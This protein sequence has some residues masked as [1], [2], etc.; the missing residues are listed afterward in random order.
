ME[1]KLMANVRIAEEEEPIFKRKEYWVDIDTMA[2]S[3]EALILMDAYMAKQHNWENFTEYGPVSWG[4]TETLRDRK[5][6]VK[7]GED[8]DQESPVNDEVI[9]GNDMTRRKDGEKASSNCKKAI[10]QYKKKH[11]ARKDSLEDLPTNKDKPTNSLEGYFEKYSAFLEMDAAAFEQH[12][13]API[14]AGMAYDQVRDAFHNDKTIGTLNKHQEMPV[15]LLTALNASTNSVLFKSPNDYL[16]VIQAHTRHTKDQL[17]KVVARSFGFGLLHEKPI[18]VCE[19]GARYLRMGIVEY[20]SWYS[21]DIK[22]YARQPRLLQLCLSKGQ[23]RLVICTLEHTP[24]P[25][26]KN[27]SHAFAFYFNTQRLWVLRNNQE[28]DKEVDQDALEGI[29]FSLY[30]KAKLFRWTYIPLS[31]PLTTK[32]RHLMKTIGKQEGKLTQSEV[33]R[34]ILKYPAPPLTRKPQAL[35][36]LSTTGPASNRQARKLAMEQKQRAEFQADEQMQEMKLLQRT[37]SAPKKAAQQTA[38][39]IM[40][41]QAD[42]YTTQWRNPDIHYTREELATAKAFRQ[43]QLILD[44][45]RVKTRADKLEQT[46][47]L[48]RKGVGHQ[49]DGTENQAVETGVKKR[50]S[51]K[52]ESKQEKLE[53]QHQKN[54]ALSTGSLGKSS[55]PSKTKS[56]SQSKSKNKENDGRSNTLPSKGTSKGTSKKS[57]NSSS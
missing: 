46:S 34:K 16:E 21:E 44:E 31:A 27:R 51:E 48:G 39:K 10:E 50:R 45:N 35:L 1:V 38:Q 5:L 22:H 56:D 4:A 57:G 55:R 20:A 3:K 26:V 23:S 25:D 29:G 40:T 15:C 49:Q 30:T 43:L 41:K 32:V 2:E 54:Q 18:A 28:P 11:T 19:F 12:M 52:N 33:D 24:S 14:Y 36:S 17:K 7:T 42:E 13:D 47:A 37:L 6:Y 9:Y 8:K 53:T